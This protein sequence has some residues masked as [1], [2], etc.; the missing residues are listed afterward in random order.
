MR[1]QFSNTHQRDNNGFVEGG[2]D[3]NL[4]STAGAASGSYSFFLPALMITSGI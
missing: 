3:E 1:M 4:P 2:V